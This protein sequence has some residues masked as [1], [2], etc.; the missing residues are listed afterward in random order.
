MK[1]SR[2]YPSILQGLFPGHP[3]RR[4]LCTGVCPDESGKN[5]KKVITIK[6]GAWPEDYSKHLDPKSY[7]GE[8][9]L[10]II[11][12][13]SKDIGEKTR[14]RVRFLSLDYD[15]VSMPMV[16]DLVA[17]LEEYRVYVYL[18]QGTTGRGVHLYVFPSFPLSQAEAHKVLITIANLSKQLK[19]PFPEFM[20]SSA[21][22]PSKG[23][24]LPY[25]GATDDGLGANPLIDPIGGEHI[26]LEAVESEVF[27][28]DVEDL[29]ALVENL[30]STQSESRATHALSY[31]RI[32]TSTYD[33]ALK[34]WDA[35]MARLK[36]VWVEGKRQNLTLGASAYGISIGMS[37]ERIRGDIETM[38]RASSNPEVDD[39]LKAVNGT[40]ERHVKGERIAWRK[41]YL[42][43]DVE[44]PRGNRIVPW[45][46][47]L[48]L[49][50]LEDRLRSSLF[51]G[52]GGFT[53]MDVLDSLIEVGKKYG[54][55]HAEG[56]EISIST[57]NL[58]LVVTG[59]HSLCHSR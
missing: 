58:A 22:G 42:L 27:R 50:V 53:D 48:R 37:A 34:A 25:R 2:D 10:G 55:L 40:I 15:S 7:A 14:W 4:L 33:G 16:M 51:K 47:T 20:P 52:M 38:E 23:I 13:Y 57:R 26:S 3:A 9:A 35:E 12:T 6:R 54:K 29:R 36:E 41:W 28:T 1:D 49:Q 5:K 24:F 18:D 45:E 11:P 46:V 19:L 56:V 30:G 17:M 39:R 8:G 21:S 43:A 32:D 31:G 44:P 59:P